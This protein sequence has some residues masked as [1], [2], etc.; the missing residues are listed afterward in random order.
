MRDIGTIASPRK[1]ASSIRAILLLA[2]ASSASLSLAR[3]SWSTHAASSPVRLACTS[4]SGARSPY[5]TPGPKGFCASNAPD[6]PRAGLP[7]PR[8]ATAGPELRES[9]VHHPLTSAARAPGCNDPCLLSSVTRDSTR[10]M[11]AVARNPPPEVAQ[12][13]CVC[14]VQ[15]EHGDFRARRAYRW[16]L[17][18]GFGFGFGFQM[19][20]QAP[21]Q[22]AGLERL[23]V[24]LEHLQPAPP[25]GRN[26]LPQASPRS[27]LGA[28]AAR[29]GIWNAS[30]AAA[31][32]RPA[33]PSA[34]APAYN[35]SATCLAKR[36]SPKDS[37]AKVSQS[38]SESRRR[39]WKASTQSAGFGRRLIPVQRRPRA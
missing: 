1:K 11:V 16:W 33:R 32:S 20:E 34:L 17:G 15:R 39:N 36:R 9:R 14:R 8:C 19:L 7:P 27:G 26:R 13:P 24:E 35:C 4:S 10:R 12:P 37:S 23:E 28:S 25:W 30:S 2:R 31:R 21:V 38:A 18:F 6:A 22:R 5:A 3:S 29:G